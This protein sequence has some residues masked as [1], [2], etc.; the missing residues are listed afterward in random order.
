MPGMTHLRHISFSAN[1]RIHNCL[2]DHQRPMCHISLAGS[3]HLPTIRKRWW[4][5]AS[6]DR[7]NPNTAFSP[8]VSN[9]S[10]CLDSLILAALHNADLD[11]AIKLLGNLKSPPS[12]DSAAATTSSQLNEMVRD[13][14]RN[15][16]EKDPRAYAFIEH[17]FR[18]LST[19]DYF[20]EKSAVDEMKIF[21]AKS[22]LSLHPSL[23]HIRNIL[24]RRCPSNTFDY[25]TTVVFPR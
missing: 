5:I 20:I 13:M 12:N 8:F 7:V 2:W 18:Y 15:L 10:I 25:G 11:A 1:H 19:L 23:L 21:F 16:D 3:V 22:V 9:E 24:L 4:S 6:N 17:L 14:F